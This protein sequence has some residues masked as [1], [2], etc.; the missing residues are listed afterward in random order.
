MGVACGTLHQ[1]GTP[2]KPLATPI[3]EDFVLAPPAFNKN[4]SLKIDMLHTRIDNLGDSLWNK[5]VRTWL[6]WRLRRLE[7]RI[8]E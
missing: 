4:L 3:K 2:P 8:P 6:R 7:R 1:V 5:V